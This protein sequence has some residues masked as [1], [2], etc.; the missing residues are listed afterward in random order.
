MLSA[1]R[2]LLSGLWPIRQI[3]GRRICNDR[4]QLL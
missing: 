2:R 3:G 4:R 1:T